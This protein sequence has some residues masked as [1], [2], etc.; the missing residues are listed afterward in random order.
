VEEF[1]T[2]SEQLARVTAECER[3]RQENARLCRLL[4]EHGLPATGVQAEP[5]PPQNSVP[6]MPAVRAPQPSAPADLSVPQKSYDRLFPNQDTMPTGGLGNLIALPLQKIP[7]RADNSAFVDGQL[8]AFPDQWRYLAGIPG[9]EPFA[10]ERLVRSLE[11]N[12]NFVGVR[13]SFSMR[14]RTVRSILRISSRSTV[15]MS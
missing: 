9:M 13:M 15:T 1:E 2:L 3:L 8:A 10:V 14:S 11:R 5:P 12:G 4:S 7:R 6:L